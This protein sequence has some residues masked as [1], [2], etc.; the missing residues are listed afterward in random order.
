M[1]F[2]LQ[3]ILEMDKPEKK[4]MTLDIATFDKDFTQPE[5][6]G[7]SIAEAKNILQNLQKTVI[8]EQIN[9]SL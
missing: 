1:R 7:L 9:K 5:H 6:I 2:K 4:S 8:E 3:L